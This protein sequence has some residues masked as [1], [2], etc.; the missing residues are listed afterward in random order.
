MRD[1][2]HIYTQIYVVRPERFKAVMSVYAPAV[3]TL[4]EIFLVLKSI[5]G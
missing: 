5:R 1:N 4:Q 3:F 2:I